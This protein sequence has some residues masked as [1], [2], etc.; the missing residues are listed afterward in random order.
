M[1]INKRQIAGVMMT[2][3]KVFISQLEYTGQVPRIKKLVERDLPEGMVESSIIIKVKETACLIKEMFADNDIKTKEVSA[4]IVSS[5]IVARA[6]KMSRTDDVTRKKLFKK[7][8]D[9]YMMFG[10]ESVADGYRISKDEAF[11]VGVREKAVKTLLAVFDKAGLKLTNIDLPFLASLRAMDKELGGNIDLYS[12]EAAMVIVCKEENS[13]VFIVREGTPLYSRKLT[14]SDV[15]ETCKEIV[16][17]SDYWEE[18]F[19]G[20]NINKTIVLGD[21]PSA[22]EIEQ[23]LADRISS[24]EAAKPFGKALTRFSFSQS[25]AMGLAIPAEKRAKF[26]FNVNLLPPGRF[27]KM[28]LER[29]FLKSFISLASVLVT[30]FLISMILTMVTLSYKEKMKDTETQLAQEINVLS[31]IERLND[32]RIDAINKYNAKKKFIGDLKREDWP[33]ILEDVRRSVPKE[34]W[35]TELFVDE[36]NVLL[37]KGKA[38]NQNAVLKYVDLLGLGE[39]IGS[40]EL[41]LIEEKDGTFE[42]NISC[43]LEDDK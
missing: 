18:Q 39:E 28:R 10:E 38:Y 7:E 21:T 8:A 24:V 14:T 26:K 35:L 15:S 12:R 17:T 36:G 2:D 13:D 9:K 20:I 31:E 6:I 16:I 3:K 27:T 33:G 1:A 4:A 41:S 40:T 32:E 25:A 19:P 23:E 5:N 42:F 29:G 22:K 11:V 43:F 37:L 34:V 30:Y